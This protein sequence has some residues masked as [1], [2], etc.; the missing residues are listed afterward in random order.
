MQDYDASSG[1]GRGGGR[2]STRTDI[3]KEIDIIM[4]L[5]TCIWLTSFV[6][7]DICSLMRRLWRVLVG[8]FLSAWGGTAWGGTAWGGT[9]CVACS[10]CCS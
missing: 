9:A 7:F 8:V 2:E 1:W 5:R 4:T 10:L 3:F 6:I